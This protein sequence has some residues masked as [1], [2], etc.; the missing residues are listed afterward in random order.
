MRTAATISA[1]RRPLARRG[2]LTGGGLVA[3]LA[4]G[5]AAADAVTSMLSALLPTLQDR[6]G[7][8][9]ATL[10]LLVATLAFSASVTQPLLGAL[11]DRLGRRLVGGLG[12]AL[13][14]SL[15]SLIGVTPT[16]PLL[17][18]LL[19]VGGLGSAALHPAGASMARA[20]VRERHTGLAVSFFGAGGTLGVALGPVVVLAVVGTFGLGATPWL[21]IPGLVLGLLTYLAV[22]PQARCS[23]PA[24]CPRLFDA[25]LFVGP[26][27]LLTLTEVASSIAFVTFTSAI[28]LWLVATHGVARDAALLGWTLAAFSLAAALGGIVAGLLS[29]RVSR[30]AIV[31][32]SM[33]LAPLPLLAVFAVEPGTPMYFLAAM[34]GGALVNAG[35]PLKVV[36]AQELAPRAVATASGMLMGF[37]MGLAGLLCVGIGHLQE[38]IGLAPAMGL[39]YLLLVPG[40]LL[41]FHT[42]ADRGVAAGPAGQAA[43]AVAA[44]VRPCL[45]SMAAY[46]AADEPATQAGRDGPAASGAQP[47]RTCAVT[48][49]DGEQPCACRTTAVATPLARPRAGA[50]SSTRRGD[51]DA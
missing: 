35:L 4:L 48:H 7:L 32:G 1:P 43:V 22:P 27:G 46:A 8:A 3:F 10:A 51:Q 49:P 39:S 34:L 38:L 12:V 47:A 11:A 2:Y 36:S 17:F 50:A 29:A 26:V 41:A 24:A 18:A 13:T 25:R 19:L 30:R 5:H 33:L 20:A 42:L 9:E 31:A 21:M 14:A 44:A 45:C 28:P 40:A 37:A 6:F 23:P 16:V 15:V